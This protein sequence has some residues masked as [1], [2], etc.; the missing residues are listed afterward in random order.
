MSDELVLH[1][2]IEV[3]SGSR[4]K[5]E[6]DHETGEIWLDRRLF[7]ATRYPA[8]YGFVPDTLAEDGDPLDVLVLLD[9]PTFPGIHVRAR[10]VGVFLMADEA[11]PDAKIIAVPYGDP[12][13]DHISSLKDVAEHLRAEIEHFFAIYKE[14]EPN[15][16]TE[17]G[18]WGDREV[19]LDVIRKSRA[20]F[21]PHPH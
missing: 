15:K 19:A 14:L 5:Y 10:A 11:G 12:R 20:A 1:V 18:D 9:D 13:W 21:V 16:M 6:I 4:N 3:P 2:V 7:T 17:V 8:D